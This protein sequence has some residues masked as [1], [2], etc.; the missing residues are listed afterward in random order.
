MALIKCV[1]CGNEVSDKAN[2]CP[3]CGAPVASQTSPVPPTPS[4]AT[5]TSARPPNSAKPKPFFTV[6][7]V[8]AWIFIVSGGWL[9]FRLLTGSSLAGAIH[10]P[11]TIVNERIQLKEG[12]AMGYGFRLPSPRQIDVEVSAQPKNINVLLMTEEQWAKYEKVKGSVWG[13]KYQYM[14]G[15][16]RQGVLTWTGSEVVPAGSWRVVVE[17]PNE[18]LLF[19]DSTNATVKITGH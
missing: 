16:S 13:G 8:L 11:Q 4:A 6:G 12:N 19:G 3:R 10:G 17:R 1:E 14:Q 5:A 15:L 2:A 18:S 7:R 9:A